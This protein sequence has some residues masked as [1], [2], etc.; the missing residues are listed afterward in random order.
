MDRIVDRIKE[1]WLLYLILLIYSI[2]IFFVISWHEPW[3]DEAQAWL[4][5]RDS[6]PF[7]LLFKNLRYEG[8]PSLWYLILIIPSKILPYR[9]I[10]IISGLI[11]I[12]GVYVLLYHSSFPKIIKL[13]LPFTYFI[14]YQY[15]VIARSYILIPI[16]LFLIARIYKNKVNR[17]YEFTIL[18]CLLAN[19]SVFTALVA[20]S[21]MFVHLIDLIK[22]RP[23]L[24]KKLIIRQ[25]KA[26]IV[27]AIAIVLIVIQLWQP[28]DSSFAKGYNLDVKHFFE[29]GPIIFNESMTEVNYVTAIALVISLLWFWQ[30]RLLLLYSLSTLSVLILFSTKYY[31]SW[32][33]GIIFLIWVFVLWLSFE[34]GRPRRLNRLSVWVR[35]MVVLSSLVVI[36]FQIYWSVSVSISDFYGPYAA[37]EAVSKYIKENKLEDKRIYATS[38]WSTETLP[39]F[40]DNIFENHNKGHKPAFW[41]WATKRDQ[42]EDLETILKDQPDLIIIGR[43][44]VDLKELPGYDFIGIFKGDLYWK[45]WIKESNDMGLFRRC[46]DQ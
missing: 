26:Y 33:Q 24:D 18:A 16:L 20:L 28:E 27:F 25:I 23:N 44:S 32:H 40:N 12:A 39:Y 30:S 42:I 36:G 35:R 31:N 45:S 3:A 4:L 46:S 11:A 41:M 13:S 37:G 21:I 8:H 15:G 1:K 5:A 43:P 22:M 19:T 29:L 2:A 34:D 9:T 17:I 6:N 10:S 14:F 7:H 38:F